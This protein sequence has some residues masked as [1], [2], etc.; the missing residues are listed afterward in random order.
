MSIAAAARFAGRGPLLVILV[1]VGIAE[2]LQA[3]F[4]F[5]GDHRLIW[6]HQD[7]PALYAAGRLVLD[8]A[9]DRLYDTPSIAAAE[10]AAAGEPVGATGVLGYFNPPFFA[11]LMAP[12]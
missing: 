10:V 4:T 1:A 12:L 8:G 5:A 11:G 3:A 9:G 2:W 6:F 7:F